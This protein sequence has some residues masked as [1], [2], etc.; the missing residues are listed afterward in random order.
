MLFGTSPLSDPE[1]S[2]ARLD[3]RWPPCGDGPPASPVRNLRPPSERVSASML[4][5]NSV[6]KPARGAGEC[7][8]RGSSA[9]GGALPLWRGLASIVEDPDLRI[10]VAHDVTGA[11]PLRIPARLTRRRET[12]RGGA[13]PERPLRPRL[14]PRPLKRRISQFFDALSSERAYEARYTLSRSDLRPGV[15]GGVG[16][17]ADKMR[18]GP[19][20]PFATSLRVRTISYAQSP[21]PGRTPSAEEYRLVTEPI[22]E[23][24]AEPSADPHT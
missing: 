14:G 21:V 6:T 15:W 18:R 5:T 1:E 9:R 3:S 10:Y 23:P 12:G 24:I 17:R 22:A 11:R 2:G 13:V 4:V 7:V 20:R 16:R 19:S 8:G